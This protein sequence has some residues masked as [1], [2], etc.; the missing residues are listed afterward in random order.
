MVKTKK[1]WT[2]R[3]LC[4][5]AVWA[6]TMASQTSKEFKNSTNKFVQLS[7][8]AVSIISSHSKR[9]KKGNQ[10]KCSDTWGMRWM[11]VNSRTNQQY[12]LLSIYHGLGLKIYERRINPDHVFRWNGLKLKLST[13]RL[14]HEIVERMLGSSNFRFN[15]VD[16]G[17]VS[18]TL[19]LY[20]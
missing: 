11:L 3:W 1:Y 8:N 9:W 15:D 5:N 20:I 10:M 2:Y 13:D 19:P 18:H 6:I 17:S 7:S 4:L 12:V 16:K 14:V